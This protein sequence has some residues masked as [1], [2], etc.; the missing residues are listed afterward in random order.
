MEGRFGVL[1]CDLDNFAH[2]HFKHARGE[3][4]PRHVDEEQRVLGRH[5]KVIRV[6]S[7]SVT[8][9]V[10]IGVTVIVGSCVVRVRVIVVSRVGVTVI[11]V[12]SVAVIVRVGRVGGRRVAVVNVFGRVTC[13]A[14]AFV[15]GTRAR[16]QE[17]GRRQYQETRG[18]QLQDRCGLH[19]C[20]LFLSTDYH[21]ST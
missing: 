10:R 15:S 19:V 21:S 1:N 20:H 7:V 14:G 16:S 5:L 11:V 8:I 6:V 9:I 13:V 12:V 3:G 18:H 2:L 4:Q 17:Y